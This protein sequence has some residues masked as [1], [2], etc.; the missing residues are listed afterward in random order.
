MAAKLMQSKRRCIR[1]G[2]RGHS[3]GEEKFS[4]TWGEVHA[5]DQSLNCCVQGEVFTTVRE[6]TVICQRVQHRAR[7]S[8]CEGECEL[9]LMN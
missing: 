4:E 8:D 2:V 3:E 1:V 9:R 7:T 6:D 5:V